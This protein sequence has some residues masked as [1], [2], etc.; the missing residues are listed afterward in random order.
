LKK[1]IKKAKS[2]QSS[3]SELIVKIKKTLSEV[4]ATILSGAKKLETTAKNSLAALAL[5]VV[6]LGLPKLHNAYIRHYVGDSVVMLTNNIPGKSESY[7]GGTGFHVTAQSGKTV[8]ISNRHV[9]MAGKNQGFMYGS[10]RGKTKYHK[11]KIVELYSNADLC[12]LEP[13]KGVKPLK[14]GSEPTEGQS[15]WAVGHPN[16][17]PRTVTKGEVQGFEWMMFAVGAIGYNDF[18]EED[19]KYANRFLTAISKEKLGLKV[20]LNRTNKNMFTQES[21]NSKGDVVL[22][23]ERN[24]SMITTVNIYKGN[25]G[26]PVVDDFGNVVSVMFATN[27]DQMWGQA[28]THYDLKNLLAKY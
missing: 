9:C 28:I 8:V 25:S 11:L 21:S 13:I 4:G 2:Q 27:N 15:V 18:S 7:G 20:I 22:C 3:A 6:I 23:V 24:L 16:L 19:C 10:V 26:S 5:L 17:Q 14:L 1:V 12:V